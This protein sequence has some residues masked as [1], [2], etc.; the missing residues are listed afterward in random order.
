M[1]S[2]ISRRHFLQTTAAIDGA[3]TYTTIAFAK[4]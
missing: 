2:Y 1:K 4:G 3:V